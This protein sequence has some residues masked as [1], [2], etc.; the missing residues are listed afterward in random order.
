MLNKAIL[1]GRLTRDPELKYTT[2]SNV[3][4][5]QFSIAVER[6]YCGK[7]DRITDFIDC[8]AWRGT[9]EFISKWFKKGHMIVVV[10][11]IQTEHWQDKNGNNRVSVKVVADEA[12]FGES[13]KSREASGGQAYTADQAGQQ[14]F[15]PG[16]DFT[17]VDDDGE[18]PF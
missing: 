14:P 18:V 2:Y 13:K 11:S 10:G 8:T 3:P 7:G 1:M 17:E 16:D 9:A 5:L 15:V 6:D 12:K 4:V